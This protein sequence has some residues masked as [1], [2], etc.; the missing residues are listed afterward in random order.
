MSGRKHKS[1]LLLIDADDRIVADVLCVKCGR[2]LR[3]FHVADRCFG[4]N[5]PASDSVHGDFL[6]HTDRSLVRAMAD[7]ARVVEY[8]IAILGSLL[9]LALL[10]KLLSARDLDDVVYGVYDVI[11]ASAVISPVV[12][13]L[14]IVL[15]TMRHSAAYFWA[16]Y[17]NRRTLLRCG[18]ALALGV[19]LLTVAFHYFGEIVLRIA[20]VLWFVLV[21]GAFLRG[22]E[23]LMGRVPNKQLASFARATLVGLVAFGVLAIL[24]ILLAHWSVTDNS[25]RDSHLAFS[26]INC[27][28][29]LALG[30]AGFTLI[31]RV[32]RTLWSIAR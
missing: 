14:G 22:I 18:L 17:G 5:H 24:I 26:G 4:C 10:A 6:I 32:R 30:V 7:A 16:R 19:A 15:L 28:G 3:G 31:V 27:L 23:R 8:G 1:S 9:G 25:W 20:L 13:V 11:F 21:V 12:G 2:N 29:G